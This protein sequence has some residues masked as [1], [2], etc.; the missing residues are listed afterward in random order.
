MAKKA[1]N[2]RH[3]MARPKSERIRRSSPVRF[4]DPKKKTKDNTKNLGQQKRKPQTTDDANDEPQEEPEKASLIPLEF[5][6]HCLNIFRDAFQPGQNGEDTA[7]LQ[8]VKGHLFNRDFATAFGREDYLRVYASRWSPSRSLGYLEIFSG[9]GELLKVE[10]DANELPKVVC[11]G[12]GSGAELVALAG[13]LSSQ[14]VSAERQPFQTTYVDVADWSYVID[15]LSKC[16]TKPPAIS[17]Y[18]SAAA[19]EANVAMLSEGALKTDFRKLDLLDLHDA[20]MKAL[21]GE[22]D[23]V[24]IM[25]TLNELYT[26]SLAKTQRM[27]R[28][29]TTSMQPGAKLL[30]VD[31]PGSYSTV[32]INGA[33]K[34]YP[35][36][37]LLDYTLLGPPK[38]P[39]AVE[40][41]SNPA[42]EKLV[43]DA[44]R[45]FRLSG[46]L[47]YPIELEN[48]RYQVHLYERL[49]QT[50]KEG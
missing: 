30:V 49:E 17:Q 9:V 18:L 16:V 21:V 19:K 24:T 34:K 8:E 10:E 35:M 7:T 38:K 27:V 12:G 6:Q 14:E 50:F 4:K 28:Q 31:S 15:A 39:D 3:I 13:W 1:I 29:L 11:L 33:E 47:K 2:Y 41:R 36:Q 45:W 26:A 22:A 48:M 40:D 43:S 32:S 46:E 37:W 44:S 23:M 20:G 5:Q 42:W 25:F